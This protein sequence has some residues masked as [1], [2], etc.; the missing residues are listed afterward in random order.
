MPVPA[1]RP[2]AAKAILLVAL[3][4]PVTIV[5]QSLWRDHNPYNPRQD[6][7]AGV[8]LRLVVDEPIV[9]DYEYEN[10]SDQNVV[11]KLNPDQKLFEFLPPA[12][13][14]QSVT[15][16]RT[17]RVRGRSRLSFRM[18]VQAQADPDNGVVVFTG[19]K[20]LAYESGRSRQEIQ[21]SG[22][23]HLNDIRN[24]RVVH[25]NDVADLQIVMAGAAIPQNQE[26]PMKQGQGEDGAPA[27]SAEL[28]EAERARLL[29]DYLNRVLGESASDR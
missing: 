5:A 6:I 13:S 8:V 7:R 26:L 15:N 18:A 23:V 27:P 22:R 17:N 2:R 21:I 19:R 28:S 12:D 25:S 14:N 11:I 9:L 24:G 3:L 10:S 1:T 4:A 20:L 16:K 29:L